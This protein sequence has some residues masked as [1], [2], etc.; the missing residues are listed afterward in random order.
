MRA[1][2]TTGSLRYSVKEDILFATGNA[3][4]VRE[5]GQWFESRGMRV[6]QAL[7]G[8]GQP[9]ELIEPQSASLEN[10]AHHKIDQ[11]VAMLDGARWVLVEDA[12]LFIP[13]LGDFPG[14]FSAHALDTIGCDG[15]LRLLSGGRSRRARF[16]AVACLWMDGRTL[17]GHGVC[18]GRI[19]SAPSGLAG[20]GCDPIFV[21]VDQPEGAGMRTFGSMTPAEKSDRSHRSAAYADLVEQ[22]ARSERPA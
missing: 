8:S 18:E 21:P 5:A 7:D 4:K 20:F 19:A 14:V 11:A 22:L 13:S 17:I 9:L 6:I 1:F 12:G 16:E 15:I 3:G 2:T 10:V